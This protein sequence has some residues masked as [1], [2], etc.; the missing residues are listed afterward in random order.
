MA[1]FGNLMVQ[2][3]E[4]GCDLFARDNFNCV[5]DLSADG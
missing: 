1:H 4:A 3:D 5:F 2:L